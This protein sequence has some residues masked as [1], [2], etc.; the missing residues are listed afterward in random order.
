MGCYH[1]ANAPSDPRAQVRRLVSGLQH[2]LCHDVVGVYLHGSLAMG[3]F[4]PLRSDADLLVAIG[5]STPRDTKLRLAWLL[6][7]VSGRPYPLEISFLTQAD[8]KPW[9]FPTPFDFHSSASPSN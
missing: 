2:A 4:N 5:E 3:C 6:L 8:L 7:E 1:W 9:W